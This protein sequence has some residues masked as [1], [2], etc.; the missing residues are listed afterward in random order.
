M[1]WF[2]N[3]LRCCALMLALALPAAVAASPEQEGAGADAGVQA[4]EAW[5]PMLWE[6]RGE[7]QSRVLLLGAIHMLQASDYPLPADVRSAYTQADRL[8]FELPPEQ[9]QSTQLAKAMLHAGVRRSGRLQDELSPVQWKALSTW[10]GQRAMP[11]ERL[12]MLKPWF[13]ALNISLQEMAASGMQAELGLDQHLMQRGLR[14]GKSMLGLEDGLAQI[15]LFDDMGAVEQQQ[16]LAEALDD[17]SGDGARRQRLLAAW[18]SGELD[19]FWAQAGE[20][21]K[22][23]YPALY[24]TINVQRNQAWLA[25]LPQWL[26]DGHGTTLVVVGALHL[27]GSDGLVEQLQARGYRVER[28]CTSAGCPKQQRRRGRR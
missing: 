26:A 14:D 28:I 6:V 13:V 17:A 1:Q 24:Q 23:T 15:A 25:Q 9:M 18:R 7:G 11:L 20:P 19:A 8:V 10:A 2:N 3:T 21:L 16:M 27:V 12:Q 4:A 5:T 22:S